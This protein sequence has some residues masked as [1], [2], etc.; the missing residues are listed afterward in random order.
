V[1][2]DGPFVSRKLQFFVDGTV[3]IVGRVCP[4]AKSAFGGRISGFT[5]FLGHMVSAAFDAFIRT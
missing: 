4:Q 1:S 2:S 3:F 5:A